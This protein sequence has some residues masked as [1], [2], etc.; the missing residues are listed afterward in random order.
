MR[1]RRNYFSIHAQIQMRSMTLEWPIQ[2]SIINLLPVQYLII[3]SIENE[4]KKILTTEKV[5]PFHSGKFDPVRDFKMELKA[6]KSLTRLPTSR[7]KALQRQLQL[8]DLL[9][10]VKLKRK[11]ILHPSFGISKVTNLP[12]FERQRKT[13]PIQN[14]QISKKKEKI[15][16]MVSLL[17]LLSPS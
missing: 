14:L 1:I 15:K 9:K 2:C 7:P 13:Y 3:K 4:A 6:G 16:L 11:L 12:I 17:L 8:V 5:S 10:H